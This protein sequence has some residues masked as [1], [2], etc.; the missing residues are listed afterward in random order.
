MTSLR[1]L[2]VL[3][4]ENSVVYNM[5]SKCEEEDHNIILSEGPV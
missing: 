1:S 2:S 3:R 5:S 4:C